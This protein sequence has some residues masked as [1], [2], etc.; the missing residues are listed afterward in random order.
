MLDFRSTTTQVKKIWYVLGCKTIYMFIYNHIR[1][2]YMRSPSYLFLNHDCHNF[3]NQFGSRF[4]NIKDLTIDCINSLI[5]NMEW[6][7]Y[8]HHNTVQLNQIHSLTTTRIAL[9]IT[10]CCQ[11]LWT[12]G[13]YFTKNR[14]VKFQLRKTWNSMTLPFWV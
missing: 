10:K 4:A 8:E 6:W 7:H 2:A 12:F 14:F 3:T 9:L 5:G 11:I 1:T 13:D